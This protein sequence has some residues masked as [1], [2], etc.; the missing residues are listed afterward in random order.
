[1]KKILKTWVIQYERN[2]LPFFL[3]VYLSADE[4]NIPATQIDGMDVLA[5]METAQPL[6]ERTRSGGGPVLIEANT[7][8]FV[9]HSMA[10]PGNYRNAIELD[11]WKKKDPLNQFVDY[12]L[13]QN[14][15]GP[16]D[17]AVID[18]R[19]KQ[20]VQDAVE[21]GEQSPEPEVESMYRDIYE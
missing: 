19:V 1:M 3:T 12:A 2:G 9:G 7:Y 21:F 13:S 8:R 5:V 10:D 15:F 11:N 6:I 14:I 4:Y 18:E 16:D 17:I 20:T